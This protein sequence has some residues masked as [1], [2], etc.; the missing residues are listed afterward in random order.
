MHG[1]DNIGWGNAMSQADRI[2]Q[3]AL[4]HVVEPARAQNRSEIEIRAGDLHKEM[5]LSNAL[6]AVCSAIGSRRFE[7]E[8]GITQ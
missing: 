7:E 2:R 6:P 8:A 1:A 5:G 4:Q 3:F